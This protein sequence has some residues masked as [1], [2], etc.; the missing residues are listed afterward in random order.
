[1]WSAEEPS[2]ARASAQSARA[3]FPL[4][5]GANGLNFASLAAIGT[6]LGLVTTAPGMPAVMTP[7]A[8]A[9]A[10]A[11]G[12][13][14]ETVL[15]SEALGFSNNVLPYQ[16]PPLVVATH[17]TDLPARATTKLS[18]ALFAATTLAILP[19]DFFWW[20]LLGWLG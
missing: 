5:P 9:L 19:L 10:T 17:L 15:M 3:A 2:A 13:P 14:L 11:T 8:G 20:R 16:S 18:L 4:A 6:V 7:L 12:L 1:M